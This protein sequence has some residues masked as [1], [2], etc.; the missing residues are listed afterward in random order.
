MPHEVIHSVEELER[1]LDILDPQTRR[2]ATRTYAGDCVMFNAKLQE[3]CGIV[4]ANGRQVTKAMR[5]AGFSDFKSFLEAFS[6]VKRERETPE[7]P[8]GPCPFCRDDRPDSLGSDEMD[9]RI[10]E[11]TPCPAIDLGTGKQ[12]DK[13]DPPYYAIGIT[14]DDGGYQLEEFIPIRYCPK[15]GRRLVSTR[16]YESLLKGL[17]RDIEEEARRPETMTVDQALALIDSTVSDI[18][19]MRQTI[20]DMMPG[21]L[22]MEELRYMDGEAVYMVYDGAGGPL[23]GW[24]LVEVDSEDEGIWLTNNLGGRSEYTFDEG[25]PDGIKLYRRKPNGDD[26]LFRTHPPTKEDSDRCEGED[27]RNICIRCG[28]FK[29]C[30]MAAKYRGEEP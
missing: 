13:A 18:Q 21:P 4:A 7:T 14:L 29:Y 12:A 2:E 11:I 8:G 26:F 25:L 6:Q 16:T 28:A 30:E 1:A 24:V 23:D 3:A 20:K 19:E 15:C 27:D 10:T 5:R 17:E 22:T 9:V